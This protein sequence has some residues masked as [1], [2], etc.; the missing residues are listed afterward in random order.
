[1]TASIIRKGQKKDLPALLALIQE[2]ATYEHAADQVEVTVETLEKEGF[3]DTPLFYFLV[4]EIDDQVVG[5]ALYFHTYSTW[6]GRV[7]YLEDLVV[8]ASFRRLGIGKLLFDRLV[9]EAQQLDAKRLCWQVLDWN[10]PAIQFYEKIQTNFD[11]EWINC[12]L[13]ASQIQNYSSTHGA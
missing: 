5:T 4:A 10:T 3:G 12:K 2:L 1:M 11:S 9:Q 6:K 8:Q 13:T 7:L